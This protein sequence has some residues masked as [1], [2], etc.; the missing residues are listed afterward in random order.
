MNRSPERINQENIQIKETSS[1][2]SMLNMS[3][4]WGL[5]Y[6][7]GWDGQQFQVSRDRLPSSSPKPPT[8]KTPLQR[9]AN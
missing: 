7:K 9:V 4:I 5:K 8:S 1:P 2:A 6:V 3:N